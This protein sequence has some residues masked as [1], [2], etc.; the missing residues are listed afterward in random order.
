[1]KSTVCIDAPISFVRNHFW[2]LFE[3][4][5]RDPEHAI[6]GVSFRAG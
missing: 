4:L 5:A 6:C 2:P 1:M 3:E